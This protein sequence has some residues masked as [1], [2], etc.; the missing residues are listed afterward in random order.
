M[1]KLFGSIMVAVMGAGIAAGALAADTSSTVSIRKTVVPVGNAPQIGYVKVTATAS[2]TTNGLT[3]DVPVP[4][5]MTS[6]NIVD[7]LGV[8]QTVSGST[9]P[10][11]ITRS[12]VT[13]TVSGTNMSS[14]TLVSG[15]VVK[16][17][18]IYQP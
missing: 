5:G 16:A 18:V 8:A 11:L 2:A 13:V 6:S 3:F 1:N 7:V 9:K 10:L 15:D 12:G 17:I 4:A 14:G